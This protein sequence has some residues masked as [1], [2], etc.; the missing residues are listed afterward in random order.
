MIRL[1]TDMRL[2]RYDTYRYI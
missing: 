2:H 1:Y